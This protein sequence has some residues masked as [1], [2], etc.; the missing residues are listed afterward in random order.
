ML[1]HL[2]SASA[3]VKEAYDHLSTELS[4][5][6]ASLAQTQQKERHS[7]SLIPE[8]TAMVK[9]QKRHISELADSKKK[10]VRELKVWSSLLC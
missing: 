1:F 9:K 7:T 8:L 5:T 4:K 6:K 2:I 3:Q 10:V